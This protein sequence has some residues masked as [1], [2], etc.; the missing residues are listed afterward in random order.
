M[1]KFIQVKPKPADLIADTMKFMTVQLKNVFAN[2]ACTLL[3]VFVDH[4]KVQLVINT[5]Q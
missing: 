1:T 4:V 5:I 3:M 2:Q